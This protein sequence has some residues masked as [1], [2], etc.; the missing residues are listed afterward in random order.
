MPPIPDVTTT[1]NEQAI[2]DELVRLKI[3]QEAKDR[4]M[5]E[6]MRKVK[7]AGGP[8]AS[9]PTVGAKD[10]QRPEDVNI[11]TFVPAK[12]AQNM[13][14][15]MKKKDVT[16]EESFFEFMFF[17]DLGIDFKNMDNFR[18]GIEF[19]KYLA[20]SSEDEAKDVRKFIR[21][22]DTFKSLLPFLEKA[23]DIEFNINTS[24]ID[25]FEK[26]LLAV[27]NCSD[28]IVLIGIANS[29]MKQIGERIEFDS[30]SM[31]NA[32]FATAVGGKTLGVLITEMYVAKL[33]TTYKKLPV[34]CPL[35]SSLVALDNP[36]V[37]G[38]DYVA[39]NAKAT[40]YIRVH[41]ELISAMEKVSVTLATK[42]RDKLLLF[43]RKAADD[44]EKLKS[45]TLRHDEMCKYLGLP[46]TRS[47]EKLDSF[48]VVFNIKATIDKNYKSSAK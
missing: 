31:L 25:R 42:L 36:I 3:E 4:A 11:V 40:K 26:I 21:Y 35:S 28:L 43:Y 10:Q 15:I 18:K 13:E 37:I 30:L 47:T 23:K 44:L 19:H 16:N 32:S 39:S 29:I 46:L 48:V 38:L 22:C 27:T 20:A 5:Q 6:R 1:P 14:L 9:Q 41:Q 7:S 33:R 24:E 17:A 8:S 45:L 34:I 2:L 12:M